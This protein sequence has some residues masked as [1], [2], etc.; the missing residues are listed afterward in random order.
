M[1]DSMYWSY[2]AA[3]FLF[4]LFALVLLRNKRPPPLPERTIGSVALWRQL[5]S[6][7]GKLVVGTKW[8]QRRELFWWLAGLAM[9]ILAA[10]GPLRLMPETDVQ[11]HRLLVIDN[12]LQGSNVP[13]DAWKKIRAAAAAIADSATTQETITIVATAPKPHLV[14]PFSANSE[15]LLASIQ[16]LAPHPA[17]A[18]STHDALALA[19]ALHKNPAAIYWIS[20]S[21]PPLLD[22]AESFPTLIAIN[23]LS[24][25]ETVSMV[26]VAIS[27]PPEK[28]EVIFWQ[29]GIRNESAVQ[30]N[31]VLRMEC[32]GVAEEELY[33]VLEAA[34][35][36]WLAGEINRP[37]AGSAPLRF[38]V[39]TFPRSGSSLASAELAIP[40]APD[41]TVEI[42]G[43]D[44]M[45]FWEAAFA[46]MPGWTTRLL[47][48]EGWEPSLKADLRVLI[49]IADNTKIE[50]ALA[51]APAWLIAS[52]PFA[53]SMPNNLPLVIFQNM[54]HPVMRGV[55][56][57]QTT[58]S[59]ANLLREEASILSVY[60]TT[61]IAD[62]PEDPLL[63][64]GIPEGETTDGG[65]R[66]IAMAFRPDASNLPLRAAFP[67]LV[68]NGALWLMDRADFS[69]SA[70]IN[71]PKQNEMPAKV[72]M[73]EMNSGFSSA[74]WWTPL[75]TGLG[76]LC[77]AV[78]ARW[79]LTGPANN[80]S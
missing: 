37:A 25:N 41:F 60:R 48:A 57:G 74:G 32:A 9:L 16:A 59:T 10:A 73:A 68:Q 71:F 1:I 29:A 78:S 5:A 62:S 7:H 28:P 54:T 43:A 64:A 35:T 55:D 15:S 11:T 30:Q 4:A 66:W 26:N 80:P 13:S 56:L 51:D 45:R 23:P 52:G 21:S 72:S 34:E 39:C 14:H 58:I 53:G 19:A 67:V 65:H 79:A 17:E 36:R 2:P 49:G 77:F 27:T 24:Q 8:W 3:F 70:S 31:L 40:T 47:P 18:R 50:R 63:L 44:E 69:N 76:L 75:L 12:R 6:R 22:P 38:E 42:V 20:S 46:A 61:S 33:L